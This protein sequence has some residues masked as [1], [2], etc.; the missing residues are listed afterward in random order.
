MSPMALGHAS[1]RRL[2]AEAAGDLLAK[3]FLGWSCVLGWRI[4]WKMKLKLQYIPGLDFGTFRED[5][6]TS[7]LYSDN[8]K[9]NGNKCL[10]FGD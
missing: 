8:G 2:G 10:G 7:E 9:E 6:V 1:K 5:R 3:L 4:T